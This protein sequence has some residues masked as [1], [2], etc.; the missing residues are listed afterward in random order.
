MG[1]K[2]ADEPKSVVGHAS[3]ASLDGSQGSSTA[4]LE[5]ARRARASSES[6]QR[7]RETS[8]V[9]KWQAMLR[10]DARDEGQN[11]RSYALANSLLGSK[12]LRRRVYKGV[13]DRWR[14][15]AWWAMLPLKTRQDIEAFG[16]VNDPTAAIPS[17]EAQLSAEKRF[18]SLAAV[19]SPHDVQID[20]DVPRTISGHVLFH[21]RYGQGQRSLFHVLHAFSLHCPDCAYCQGMGPIAATL[22]VYLPPE[23]A[24]AS[25]VALHDT[26]RYALHRTFSPGFPGLVE[27][28]YVQEQLCEL[29]M[30]D[31]MANFRAHD[32]S[33]SAYATKWYITLFANVVPF[34]TQIRLWDAMLLEGVDVLVAFAL[35]ILWA[36]RGRLAA[37][38]AGFEVILGSLGAEFLPTDDDMLLRWVSQLL[39]RDDVR[40]H[41]AAARK[42]WRALEASGE[43][44]QMIT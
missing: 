6:A 30:P 42:K 16:A 1:R 38:A 41:M 29:F 26:P 28:F 44:L 11:V 2:G 34:Q 33:T 18:E 4:E 23:R 24:Y 13:P 9:S 3:S 20:L 10:P 25:L 31:L 15:A 32:I 14:A 35:A 36:Q 22:L 39:A 5:S 19:A 7:V 40:R 27:N 17:S 8:R 43:A 12:K 37:K 21:T